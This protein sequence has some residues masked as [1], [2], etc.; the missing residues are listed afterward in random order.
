MLCR[1]GE[2]DPTIGSAHLDPR[3]DRRFS[4]LILPDNRTGGNQRFARHTAKYGATHPEG[5]NISARGIMELE[6]LRKLG[7][8]LREGIN[9]EPQA[10]YLLVAIRKLLEKLDAK[11]H[12]AKEQYGYLNFHCDWALHSQ[13]NRKAARNVLK[14]FD[15]ANTHLKTGKHLHELPPHLQTRL[16]TF[17]R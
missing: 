4:F 5:G 7:T 12:G 9:R 17:R 15:E 8:L 16:T 2:A 13:L 6:I 10:V 11:Q 1:Y 14:H 3:R